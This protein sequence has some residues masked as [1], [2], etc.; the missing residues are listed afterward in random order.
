MRNYY[1]SMASTITVHKTKI[2]IADNDLKLR[3][4]ASK[5]GLNLIMV[6]SWGMLGRAHLCIQ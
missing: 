5:Q 4:N 6:V 1:V 3:E 2:C